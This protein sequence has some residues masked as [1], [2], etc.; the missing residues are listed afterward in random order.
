MATDITRLA[1]LIDA[2]NAQPGTAGA[3]L[4]E[5]AKF[6]TAHVKR[7]YGD[8]TGTRLTGWKEH[9]LAESIQPMQ[10]FA[11]TSGKNATD[12]IRRV[13]AM[14]SSTRASGSALF[15]MIAQSLA[16]PASWNARKAPSAVESLTEPTRTRFDFDSRKCFRT[17]SSEVWNWPSPSMDTVRQRSALD[18]KAEGTWGDSELIAVDPKTGVLYGGHAA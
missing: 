11:Y 8:W 2:D 18:E 3:L 17:R 14:R 4:A 12:A 9:L 5:V 10:Q 7:A 15:P 6:G 13:F 16:R 1:V